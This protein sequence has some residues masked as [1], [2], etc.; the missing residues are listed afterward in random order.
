MSRLQLSRKSCE[1]SIGGPAWPSVSFPSWLYDIAVGASRVCFPAQ[2]TT[3]GRLAQ[4]L[5]TEIGSRSHAVPHP[6][7]E[8]V[9]HATADARIVLIGGAPIDGERH[10]WWN[11][12]S[13]SNA[14]IEQ[15]KR[16]WKEGRFPKVPGT[17]SNRYHFQNET[18]TRPPRQCVLL[19]IEIR[20]TMYALWQNR[21]SGTRGVTTSLG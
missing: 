15:A 4:R 11:F 10:I 2:S 6:G 13:S 7:A 1:A 8:V 9:L 21:S 18:E 12:V 5:G 16:D 19:T 20:R 14:R 17:R 3:I